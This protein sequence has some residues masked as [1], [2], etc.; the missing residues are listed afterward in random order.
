MNVETT[1]RVLRVYVEPRVI[2]LGGILELTA[3]GSVNG[4]SEN[5][6]AAGCVVPFEKNNPACI[7][8]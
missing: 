3:S 8:I 5:N 2:A 4:P 6:S 7:K 1:P